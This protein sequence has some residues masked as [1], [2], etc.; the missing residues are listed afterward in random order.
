M[1]PLSLKDLTS[2]IINNALHQV[3]FLIL[4]DAR[5]NIQKHQQHK[6][7][8][9]APTNCYIYSTN[10]VAVQPLPASL[11][12]LQPTYDKRDVELCRGQGRGI[13]A[14]KDHWWHWLTAD[15]SSTQLHTWLVMLPQWMCV[16]SCVCGC[17]HV[18]VCMPTPMSKVNTCT[19]SFFVQFCL[20]VYCISTFFVSS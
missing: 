8:S 4:K 19:L 13:V 9:Q 16:C 10:R 11:S 1:Y 18:C 15:Y 5:S 2:K 12:L 20:H 17:V 6:Q 14:V 7:D 3:P